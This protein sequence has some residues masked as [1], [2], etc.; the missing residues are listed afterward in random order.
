MWFY[1]PYF[2]MCTLRESPHSTADQPPTTDMSSTLLP[3]PPSSPPLPPPPPPATPPSLPTRGPSVP[4]SLARRS[5]ALLADAYE[6]CLRSRC[7]L[8]VPPPTCCAPPPAAAPPLVIAAL[9]NRVFE[10][11]PLSQ[12]GSFAGDAARLAAILLEVAPPPTD[13]A[14][15]FNVA[16]VCAVI[17]LLQQRLW[18]SDGWPRAVLAHL[19]RDVHCRVSWPDVLNAPSTVLHASSAPLTSTAYVLIA[20]FALRSRVGG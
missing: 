2:S 18:L 15:V 6:G 19:R 11:D 7:W 12:Y 14:E 1:R 5:A 8:T 13:E 4:L 20:A 10:L 16:L 17:V 9:V 3:L